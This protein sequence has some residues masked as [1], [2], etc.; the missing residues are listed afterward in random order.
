[1]AA[2]SS[3]HLAF[4]WA[5]FSLV[6]SGA[7][8]RGHADG[9][10]GQ[11]VVVDIVSMPANATPEARS[12]SSAGAH[13]PAQPMQQRRADAADQSGPAS[14][15]GARAGLAQN[16]RTAPAA[17]PSTSRQM[18]DLPDSEVLAY[19]ALL[20]AHLARYRMYPA[21]ARTDGREGVVVL[22]FVADRDGKVSDA[23]IETS[24]GASTIDQEALAAVAR[25]QPLPKFPDDW[26]DRL[27]VSL[28]VTFKLG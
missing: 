1:L 20:E 17:S 19:R 9:D 22:H 23:W 28:P 18:A 8:M 10:G 11:A 12:N 15:T 14:T 25:A 24:S 13:H 26:P 5:L 3:A 21:A 6:A 16:T 27:D 2:S 4:G 7:P